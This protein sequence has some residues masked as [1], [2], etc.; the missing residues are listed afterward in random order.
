[1]VIHFFEKPVQYQVMANMRER[2]GL[3]IDQCGF[4][5]LDEGSLERFFSGGSSPEV[6]V[7]CFSGIGEAMSAMRFLGAP[8]L[9][10]D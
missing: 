2:S 9:I 7:V 6:N 1:M 3:S 10:D 5:T 4:F 8:E